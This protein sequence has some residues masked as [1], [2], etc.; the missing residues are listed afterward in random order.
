MMIIVVYR[1]THHI[2]LGTF[3]LLGKMLS[4]C[5]HITL[6]CMTASHFWNFNRIV[7]LNCRRFAVW[8]FWISESL[9]FSKWLQIVASVIVNLKATFKLFCIRNACDFWLSHVPPEKCP[10]TRWGYVYP[11]FSPTAVGGIQ[12]GATPLDFAGPYRVC[13]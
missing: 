5:T 7:I 4:I 1:P 12:R 10:H 13:I 2:S 9:Q 6:T 8:K 3:S 11:W